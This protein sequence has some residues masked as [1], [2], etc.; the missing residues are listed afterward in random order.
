MKRQFQVDLLDAQIDLNHFL[1]FMKVEMA[2][3]QKSEP[4]KSLTSTFPWSLRPAS[5]T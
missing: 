5:S 4:H 2:S 3:T 1:F